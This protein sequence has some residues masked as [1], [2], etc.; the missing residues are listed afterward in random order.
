MDK[1]ELRVLGREE[2]VQLLRLY[3][4]EID[5]CKAETVAKTPGDLP[6]ALHLADS[7]LRRYRQFNSRNSINY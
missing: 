6:L 2:S 4:D 3:R 7:F 5:H 1:V